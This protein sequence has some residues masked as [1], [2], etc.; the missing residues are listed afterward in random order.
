MRW[1]VC[2]ERKFRLTNGMLSDLRAAGHYKGK[3]AALGLVERKGYDAFDTECADI[4]NA[5]G[6]HFRRYVRERSGG[7]VDIRYVIVG[8]GK[9]DPDAWLLAGKAATDGMVDAGFLASDRFEVG[10]VSG[11]V[12]R[13]GDDKAWLPLVAQSPIWKGIVI[14]VEE[15]GGDGHA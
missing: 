12:F 10:W 11:K 4:R 1:V 3:S 7:R 14:I 13:A 2:I 8:H 6:L 15:M 5:V 9:C